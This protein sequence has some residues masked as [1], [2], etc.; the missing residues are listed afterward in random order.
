MIDIILAG[1]TA[2][3]FAFLTFF[4]VSLSLL[5]LAVGLFYLAGW[6]RRSFS[7]E[8]PP[9]INERAV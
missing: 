3:L 6:V 7:L 4:I 8:R 9:V 5:S 2:G 1:L